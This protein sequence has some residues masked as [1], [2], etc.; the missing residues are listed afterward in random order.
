MASISLSAMPNYIRGMHQALE[1]GARRGLILAGER[2]VAKIVTEII[3]SRSPQPVDRATYK[4]GWKTEQVTKDRVDILNSEPHAVF[5]EFGVR[6]ENVRIGAALIKA[7][8]EWA[9]RKGIAESSKEAVGV[10]W[11]VA[12]GMQKKGIFNR[13]TGGGLRILEELET[14]YLE[15]I[16]QQEVVREINR[17]IRRIVRT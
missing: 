7:L 13:R 4:A 8:S 5:I 17:E 16:L 14:E 2:G 1:K 6:A 12:K 11:A 3:P 15:D 10:A 9:L